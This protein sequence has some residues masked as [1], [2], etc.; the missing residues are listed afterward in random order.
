VKKQSQ[1]LLLLLLMMCF[2]ENSKT[3]SKRMNFVL[4]LLLSVHSVLSSSVIHVASRGNDSASCGSAVSP[5]AT[6]PFAVGLAADNDTISLAAE[7]FTLNSIVVVNRNGLILQGPASFDRAIISAPPTHSGPMLFVNETVSAFSLANVDFVGGVN[8]SALLFNATDA[9][10]SLVVENATFS[11]FV[12]YARFEPDN[13]WSLYSIICL[14]RVASNSSAAGGNSQS[15]SVRLRD[16]QFA[17]IMSLLLWGK[18]ESETE[19]NIAATTNI[20]DGDVNNTA[21]GLCVGLSFGKNLNMSVTVE[22]SRIEV[23]DCWS[24]LVQ[25][26]IAVAWDQQKSSLRFTDVSVQNSSTA[27]TL[28]RGT[29]TGMPSAEPATIVFANCSFRDTSTTN[30]MGSVTMTVDGVSQINM[31]GCAIVNTQQI[32]L[33]FGTVAVYVA[34][35]LGP[36]NPNATLSFVSVDIDNC[37]FRGNGQVESDAPSGA[38][39]IA[40]GDACITTVVT[41]RNSVFEDNHSCQDCIGKVFSGG[42]IQLRGQDYEALQQCL[43]DRET[44]LYVDNSLFVGNSAGRGGAIGLDAVCFNV[45]LNVTIRRSQFLS[46]VA[47]SLR[48]GAGGALVHSTAASRSDNPGRAQSSIVIEDCR[49]YNNSAVK[50]GGAVALSHCD[51]ISQT[52]LTVAIRHTRIFANIASVDTQISLE[53]AARTSISDST[54]GAIGTRRFDSASM[55]LCSMENRGP[56]GQLNL[57]NTI[58][59]C[60]LGDYM[61]LDNDTVMIHDIGSS[62]FVAMR[63]FPCAPGT[64]NLFGET[65]LFDA[66]GVRRP[67]AFQC[68]QCPPG[69][70]HNCTGNAVG[71]SPGFWSPPPIESNQTT[72][73]HFYLCPDHYCCDD[74]EGCDEVHACSNN[75][76]GT[77]CGACKPGFVHAF[78]LYDACVS[79]ETCSSAVVWVGN[80][81][82]VVACGAL[83]LYLFVRKSA[84]SDGLLKVIVAFC[85]IAQV[86]VSNSIALVPAGEAGQATFGAF[87]RAVFSLMSGLVEVQ[88]STTAYCPMKSM[89][90]MEKL[91]MPLAVPVVLG[92]FWLSMSLVV[93]VVS[94]CKCRKATHHSTLSENDDVDAEGDAEADVIRERLH[95]AVRAHPMYKVWASLLALLDFS[96]FIVVGVC[97]GLLNT[98]VV[99]DKITV[100]AVPPTCRFWKAGDAACDPAYTAVAVVLLLVMLL[101]PLGLAVVQRQKRDSIL[102]VAIAD[103]YMS[104]MSPRT[105]MYMFAITARRALM[106]FV[107]AFVTLSGLR[108]VLIRTILLQAFLLHLFVQQPFVSKWTNRADALSLLVLLSVM[109]L[110]WIPSNET[111]A[112]EFAIVRVVQIIILTIGALVLCGGFIVKLVPKRFLQCCRGGVSNSES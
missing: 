51:T 15:S 69:A 68:H 99:I 45:R 70:R 46:N 47:G 76:S 109:L 91:M 71:A 19:T 34:S 2:G 55:Q 20:G 82:V 54:I 83:V 6:I 40:T 85:N 25:S 39:V 100:V 38:L 22:L 86:V 102:G 60:G 53:L 95:D 52:L 81:L 36:Y 32:G 62:S 12:R 33:I 23:R 92:C 110:Q 73:V 35:G 79:K 4:L 107:N 56:V 89:T 58:F 31:T 63:C 104:A 108:I 66:S 49:F 101:G 5:C 41:V 97:V 112:N 43:S 8:S 59:L 105:H 13:V 78:S 42:A 17:N 90:S 24:P 80:T 18:S 94:K 10:A 87:I 26:T 88:F 77:L 93:I 21:F 16:L 61:V 29:A 74:I 67:S 111:G 103:T 65:A 7:P 96:L 1:H 37:V 11:N 84:T 9:F 28:V 64:Y 3:I 27:L 50:S 14:S 98:V 106:A 57:N 30:S 72:L 75:R 44:T 48:N